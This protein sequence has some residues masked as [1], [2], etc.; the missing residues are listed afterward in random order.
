MSSKRSKE[1]NDANTLDFVLEGDTDLF[2]LTDDDDDD[3]TD[4]QRPYA[5]RVTGNEDHYK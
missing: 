5:N 3:D 4:E 2:D 1:I